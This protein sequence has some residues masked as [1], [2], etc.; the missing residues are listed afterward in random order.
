MLEQSNKPIK[1]WQPFKM[2]QLFRPDGSP[3]LGISRILFESNSYYKNAE[4]TT[5]FWAGSFEGELLQIDWDVK[6]AKEEAQAEDGK[7]HRVEN[8]IKYFEGEMNWRP[9]LA[10]ERSPF[11]EDLVM[12]VH[13]FN[14]CIWKTSAYPETMHPIFRSAQS[15][16]SHNTCGAFS[17]TRPGVI[18]ITKTDAIDIWDFYDQSNKPSITLPLATSSITYFTFQKL[19]NSKDKKRTK[20][21]HQQLAYG[22]MD[23]GNLNL[24]EVP[25]NLAKEQDKE[26]EVIKKFWDREYEKCVYVAERKQ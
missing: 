14:F 23:T 25:S 3:D 1:P 5:T 13:D 6:V 16:G 11:Y 19:V 20:K 2:I 24:A 12:T 26:L 22:E 10:I 21:G 18:F 4:K 17:P 9:V 8:V 15:F 7:P